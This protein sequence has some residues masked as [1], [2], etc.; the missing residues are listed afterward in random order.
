MLSNLVMSHA[1]LAQYSLFVLFYF[2]I[3]RFTE[4]I[5]EGDSDE[6][7]RYYTVEED[8]DH[9]T[10][11]HLAVEQNF[12]RVAKLLVEKYPSLVYTK[13]WRVGDKS[14]Y[15]PVEKAL[16][17]YSDEVSAYLILQMEPDRYLVHYWL[18]IGQ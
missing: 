1:V 12:V 9:P 18:D 11:L 10:L 17:A 6:E 16:M 3:S 7:F 5:L 2:Q 13:T 14:E 15:L 4:I 8:P